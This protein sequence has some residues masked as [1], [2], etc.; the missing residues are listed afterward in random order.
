[1]HC[2]QVAFAGIWFG[3]SAMAIAS[4][5][6]SSFPFA[7]A[8]EAKWVSSPYQTKTL[9]IC[10]RISP[11]PLIAFVE[12]PLILKLRLLKCFEDSNGGARDA[13][14]A[15]YD[16]SRGQSDCQSMKCVEFN[17]EDLDLI[18]A[19]QKHNQRVA[20]EYRLAAREGQQ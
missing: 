8:M 9:V 5:L 6:T 1:M 16:Q 4:M 10:L 19:R 11:F 7:V 14:A 18:K 15:F 2:L 12:C 13:N 17:D 3:V 20:A